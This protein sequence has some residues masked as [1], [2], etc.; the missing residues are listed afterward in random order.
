V[1]AGFYRITYNPPVSSKLLSFRVDSLT[2]GTGGL[3]LGTVI[4]PQG[5][6]LDITVLA[7]GTNAPVA[8]A[9]VDMIDAYTRKILVTIND[10]SDANGF[11]RIVVDKNLYDV[12]IAPPDP[13][14]YDSVRIAGDL[15]TLSDTAITVF[16]PRKVLAVGGRPRTML[17]FASAWPNPSRG[18]MSFAFSGVGEG[19]LEILDVSGRRV[20]MP[21]HGSLAGASTARWEG[22][23]ERGRPAPNGVYFARLHLGDANRTRRIVLTR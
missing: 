15:R 21:W 7:Q 4:P 9:N 11:M 6:W 19:E 18:A 13:A 8:N 14:L 3:N 22:S 17:D 5:H 2:V 16:M 10:V 23:D 12:R 1:P 20:A